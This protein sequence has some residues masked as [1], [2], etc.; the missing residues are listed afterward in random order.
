MT[1]IDNSSIMSKEEVKDKLINLVNRSAQKTVQE[2]AYDKTILAKIQYCSDAT[3]GQYKIQYQNGYYTAYSK[4]TSKTYSN[5]AMVYV[6]VPSN[7]L[8]NRL[9][10]QD[11]ANNDSSKRTYITNLQGDQQYTKHGSSFIESELPNG[12]NLSSHWDM[13]GG[14]TVTYYEYTPD[15]INPNNK[16]TLRDLGP[17]THDVQTGDGYLRIGAK[18]KTSVLIGVLKSLVTATEGH[19]TKCLMN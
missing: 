16:L 1:H 17:I 19:M 5:G 12:L 8:S 7:D 15:G 11:L 10:I 3:L 9:F 18:F 4:D 2:S 6:T 14:R 13:P